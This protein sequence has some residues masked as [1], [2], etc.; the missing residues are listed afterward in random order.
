VLTG[1]G[2][3][4]RDDPQLNVRDVHTPRQPLRIVVDSGLDTPPAARVVSP[5]TLIVA[6]GDHPSRR[7]AL[8]ARGA[9]VIAL[10]DRRGKVD[11]AALMR[12]LARREM[13]EVHVEAGGTLNGSLLEE[14]LVDEL[15]VY[16]APRLIGES[17]RGMFELPELAD[18]A[19]ARELE[20]RDIAMVGPDI[21]VIARV[22]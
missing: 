22:R 6:A 7:E 9:C 1:A 10:P 19:G 13:N 8:E 15:I 2:T 17:A 14:G 11:L 18:W 4:G 3:V 12:E 20:C 16:L 5:G 21:R